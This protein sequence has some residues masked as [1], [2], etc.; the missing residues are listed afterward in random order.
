MASLRRVAYEFGLVSDPD[1]VEEDPDRRAELA[2]EIDV[3]VAREIYGLNK[4]EMRYILDPANILGEECEIETFKAL[5]NREMREFNEYRTQR[6]VLEAWDRLAG[7]EIDTHAIDVQRPP[8]TVLP[9]GSWTRP[10]Q[11][12]AG[13]VGVALSAILKAMAGPRPAGDVRLAAALIL[14]PR[15]L[16]PLLHEQQASEWRRLIGSEA[17]PLPGNVTAFAMRNNAAWGAAVRNNR[18]NG[19]LVEDLQA[20]RGRR[21]EGWMRSIQQVGRTVAPDLS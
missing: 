5:R 21:V 8:L 15:L 20:V 13:D 3:L 12:Q 17:D 11:P 18:G 9:N 2:A 19:R 4:Q 1:D 16:V 7:T 6:L 10:A 14:E